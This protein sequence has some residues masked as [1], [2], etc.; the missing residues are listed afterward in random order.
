MGMDRLIRPLLLV[1]VM[2]TTACD[3]GRS[4]RADLSATVG[5]LSRDGG[6]GPCQAVV[7]APDRALTAAHC[8]AEAVSWRPPAPGD[9]QLL[10]ADHAFVVLDAILPAKRSLAPS[11]AI[12]DLQEDWAILRIATDDGARPAPMVLGGQRAAWLAFAFEEPV[13]K[14]GMVRSEDGQERV[15]RLS[16]CTI[17]TLA[18]S[19]GLLTYSCA[20]GT[21]PGLSGSPLLVATDAGYQVIGVLSARERLPSGHE[22]GIVVIPP[23]EEAAAAAHPQ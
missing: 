2:L 10:T 17:G 6:T 3:G 4:E 19:R 21:G 22:V 15:E 9:V 5:W 13:V 1:L 14:A 16:D 11:G 20:G 18:P 8:V 7:I 23:P 12:L